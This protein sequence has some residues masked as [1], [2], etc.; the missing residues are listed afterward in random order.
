MVSKLKLL[1]WFSGICVRL[2]VYTSLGPI[3]AGATPASHLNGPI[4]GHE[5]WLGRVSTS[6]GIDAE[7]HHLSHWQIC[8]IAFI[9]S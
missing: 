3:I 4:C 9:L 8:D 7:L 2:S 1:H 5:G 6:V